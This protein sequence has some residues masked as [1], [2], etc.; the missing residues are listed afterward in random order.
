[1][2]T[3]NVGLPNGDSAETLASTSPAVTRTFARPASIF[4]VPSVMDGSR[5]SLKL[6]VCVAPIPNGRSPER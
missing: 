2:A 4:A 6:N 1:L 5:G 3:S